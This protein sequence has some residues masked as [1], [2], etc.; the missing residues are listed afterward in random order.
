MSADGLG[1]ESFGAESTGVVAY[2]QSILG[3][4]THD[5]G[6]FD[7]LTTGATCAGTEIRF[8]IWGD[9][10]LFFSDVSPA[11]SGIRHFASYTYGP[12][13]G[14]F[15]DPFGLAVDGGVSVGDTVDQLV[16]IYPAAVINESGQLG[17]AVF[18]IEDGLMGFLTGTA[19]TDTITTF[20][21]GFGCGE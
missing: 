20:V 7:P 5:T 10:S 1:E 4:P 19:G 8:V 11:V 15:I 21:G 14:P 9:L 6:W 16:T 17:P 3:P 13:A 18:H 2:V 12:T